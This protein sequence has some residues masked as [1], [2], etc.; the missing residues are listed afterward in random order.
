M[1]EVESITK[2]R[3]AKRKL[4]EDL[5]QKRLDS[6]M[7]GFG[8]ISMLLKETYQMITLGGDAELEIVSITLSSSKLTKLI[9]SEK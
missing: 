5:K 6:F 2:D 1:A 7:Q 3:T 4:L 9:T 8:V